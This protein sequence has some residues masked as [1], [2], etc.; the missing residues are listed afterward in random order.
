M[1]NDLGIMATGDSEDHFDFGG[2]ADR[3]LRCS[4]VPV[5]GVPAQLQIRI[6]LWK[7]CFLFAEASQILLSV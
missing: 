4:S 5:A 3:V 2:V 7:L 1:D 6:Y